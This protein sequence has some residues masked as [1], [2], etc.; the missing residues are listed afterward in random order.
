MMKIW[1]KKPKT[2]ALRKM[3]HKKIYIRKSSKYENIWQQNLLVQYKMLLF[4]HYIKDHKFKYVMPVF[5]G[6]ICY[7]SVYKTI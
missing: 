6:E 3:W 2:L 5:P 4:T 1:L 7:L